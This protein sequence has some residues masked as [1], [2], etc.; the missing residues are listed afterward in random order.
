MLSNQVSQKTDAGQREIDSRADRLSWQ[1]RALL[2]ETDGERS[3]AELANVFKTREATV[4]A[5]DEL[6][7]LGLIDIPEAQ[8]EM[9][10]LVAGEGITPLQRARR[11]NDTAVGSV[12]VSG[13]IA[14]FRFTLKIKHCYTAAEPRAVHRLSQAGRE[15][16]GRRLCRDGA[17]AG[18]EAARAGLSLPASVGRIVFRGRKLR[19]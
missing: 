19:N 15:V 5:F 7:A 18:G 14:A 1:L 4:T 11:L 17:G 8:V 12:G 13:G 2:I 10:K 16:Q 6:Y 3:V 9:P